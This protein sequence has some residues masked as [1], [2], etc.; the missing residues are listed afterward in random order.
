[1]RS[2][3]PR[4]APGWTYFDVPDVA[5]TSST[6]EGNE[7]EVEDPKVEL[8]VKSLIQ[9]HTL[10]KKLERKAGRIVLVS[11]PIPAAPPP[12]R[13]R[14]S[15]NGPPTVPLDQQQ[16]IGT[17]SS[18]KKET[19]DGKTDNKNDSKEAKSPSSDNK[20]NNDTKEQKDEKT[21]RSLGDFDSIC[22]KGTYFIKHGR[23]GTPH[24]KLIKV[25][26]KTGIVDWGTGSINLKE[27][28]EVFTF[29]FVISLRSVFGSLVCG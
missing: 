20:N 12:R 16:K 25:N 27:A 14:L 8:L 19:K 5:T 22:S 24:P 29:L 26:T 15:A 4:W 6:L 1:M 11:P 2:Q 21:A 17:A 3:R 7:E 18:A 10:E 9:R 28:S 23:V 13:S